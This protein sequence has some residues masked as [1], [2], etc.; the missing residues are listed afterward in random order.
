MHGHAP[1]PLLLLTPPPC[2]IAISL[3]SLHLQHR[4]FLSI[5]PSSQKSGSCCQCTLVC[6]LFLAEWQCVLH[7][8]LLEHAQ[9]LILFSREAL[10]PSKVASQDFLGSWEPVSP[11]L[12]LWQWHHLLFCPH[13][14]FVL[15]TILQVL[16]MWKL[17][18]NGMDGCTAFF[19]LAIWFSMN[20]W[21]ELLW[22][23]SGL[24]LGLSQTLENK[25]FTPNSQC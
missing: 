13:C 11:Q 5:G 6:S 3:L 12:L 19:I 22:K 24:F 20:F 14:Y 23:R 18:R 21:G 17:W 16:S 25:L 10:V 2:F 8:L 4:G 9:P 1:P 15:N 7:V